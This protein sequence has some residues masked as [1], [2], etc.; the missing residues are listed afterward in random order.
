MA[1]VIG[2]TRARGAV[3]QRK[4]PGPNAAD[5]PHTDDPTAHPEWS[6]YRALMTDAGFSENVVENLWSLLIGGLREQET[7]NSA[8]ADPSLTRTERRLR[9]EGN[10]WYQQAGSTARTPPTSG[11]PAS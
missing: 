3:V 10:E 11:G 6:V 9:R 2:R 5:R 4:F 1:R 8:S 7:I